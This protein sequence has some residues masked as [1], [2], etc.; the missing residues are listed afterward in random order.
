M[1][2]LGNELAQYQLSILKPN[3]L[4]KVKC[5]PTKSNR[6]KAN[7]CYNCILHNTPFTDCADILKLDQN[8][9]FCPKY[10]VHSVYRAKD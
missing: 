8:Q 5:W 1:P 6:L 7:R 4:A 3:S 2:M 10:C 9:H